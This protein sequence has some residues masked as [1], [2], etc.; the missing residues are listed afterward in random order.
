M[1]GARLS[2]ALGPVRYGLAVMNGVPVDDRPGA[3]TQTYTA[4]KTRV[5]RIGLTT[6]PGRRAEVAGG[7]S[8]LT[9]TGFHAG[10]TATKSQLL[11][12]DLNQ[13]GLVALSELAAQPGQAATP[14]ETY[15]RWGLNADLQLGLETPIGWTRAYGEVTLASNLDRGLFVA[16]P[17]A[18][19]YDLRELA[20]NVALV[21]DLSDFG[22]AGVRIDAYDGNADATEAR[23]G[24]FVPTDQTITTISPLVGLVLP[25]VGRLVVQYDY[26]SD[27]LGRD[28]AA[29]PV[30]LA[31][32][33][34]TLRVQV[35]L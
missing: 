2:G 19:G 7:L 8:A 3:V 32:D 18:T 26:V 24:L 9:G 5:G 16:D 14:S 29:E 17:I 28:D 21:Q 11:W 13:D 4:K 15:E 25:T 23:R 12:R 6:P 31:N 34:L 20:W 27:H 22:F 1:G 10:N 33:V 35:E 30:D